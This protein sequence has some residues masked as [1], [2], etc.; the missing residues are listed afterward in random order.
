MA[1]DVA[2]ATVSFDET[3]TRVNKQKL[4]VTGTMSWVA[5][6]RNEQWLF[7]KGHSFQEF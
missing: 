4:D 6:K 1:Q 3:L 2:I 7:I 5:L